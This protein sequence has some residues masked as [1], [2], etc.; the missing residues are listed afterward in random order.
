[1]IDPLYKIKQV[2]SLQRKD[3]ADHVAA[4]GVEDFNAYCKAVGAIQAL[5][6]ILSEIADLERR[7]AEEE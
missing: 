6:L 2:C 1:M 3:L 4:G 5:D 7:A